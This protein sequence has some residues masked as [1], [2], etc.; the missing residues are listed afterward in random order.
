[1]I[2]WISL[3]TLQSFIF[4]LW[5]YYFESFL[6]FSWLIWLKMVNPVNVFK[7]LTL[8]LIHSL[9][10]FFSFCFINFRPGFYYLLPSTF[11]RYCFCYPK[12]SGE[13]Y[14]EIASCFDVG[15]CAMKFPI[16][17]AVIMSHRLLWWLV[18]LFSFNSRHF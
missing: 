4:R 8:H 9:S 6:S 5:L 11:K 13:H 1:M 17:S 10:F 16:R 2:L 7:E 3:V 12:A 15:S 14:Y 18:F